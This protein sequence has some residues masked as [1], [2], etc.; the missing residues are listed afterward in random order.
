MIKIKL[1]HVLSG[2]AA[3]ALSF[4]L[5]LLW[6]ALSGHQAVGQTCP[7]DCHPVVSNVIW[8]VCHCATKDG[9]KRLEN[10]EGSVQ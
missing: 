3:I 7:G 8:E 1:T 10:E 6:W 9:W 2:V 4:C 5:W